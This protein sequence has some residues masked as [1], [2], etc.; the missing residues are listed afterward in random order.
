MSVNGNQ[1]SVNSE[2]L[3]VINEAPEAATDHGIPIT[4][5]L[6]LA[7]NALRAGQIVAVKGLG[8]FHLTLDGCLVA[9]VHHQVKPAQPLDRYDL[10]GAQGIG[11]EVEVI[12]DWYTAIGR[13]FRRLIDYR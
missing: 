6:Y 3:A 10:P 8:G 13:C 9:G 2:Q 1:L 7:A 4:D 11:G 5:H 12:G